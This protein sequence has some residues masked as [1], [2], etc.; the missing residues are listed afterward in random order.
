MLNKGTTS[1]L[2][3]RLDIPGF[4]SQGRAKLRVFRR[5]PSTSSYTYDTYYFEDCFSYLSSQY[6][7]D[8]FPFISKIKLMTNMHINVAWVSLDDL[9]SLRE[10]HMRWPW[11]SYSSQRI[12]LFDAR[13]VPPTRSVLESHL[14][15]E[16]HSSFLEL[17]Q[18]DLIIEVSTINM[19]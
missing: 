11:W 8:N 15:T 19:D 9:R 7:L 14:L 13:F 16:H 2:C 18:L 6:W 3:H 17:T 5:K 1:Q 12:A 10:G 4:S